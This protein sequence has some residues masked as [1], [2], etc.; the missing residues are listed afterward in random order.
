MWYRLMYQHGPVGTE[1]T[2][3]VLVVVAALRD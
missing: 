1:L 2:E 3:D